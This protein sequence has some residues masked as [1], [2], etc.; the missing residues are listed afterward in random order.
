MELI[1][2][3][4]GLTQVELAAKAGVSRDVIWRIER[5]HGAVVRLATLG[6]LAMALDV[7]LADLAE[8]VEI[9]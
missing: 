4:R 3:A 5:S 7:D 1:R 2:A 9:A 8:D 6:R